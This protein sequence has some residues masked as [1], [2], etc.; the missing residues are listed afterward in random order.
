MR[1]RPPAAAL[2]WL[3]SNSAVLRLLLV[4]KLADKVEKLDVLF[5]RRFPHGRCAINQLINNQ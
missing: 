2:A 3:I 4:N 1:G 5:W